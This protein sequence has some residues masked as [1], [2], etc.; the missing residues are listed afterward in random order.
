[1]FIYS[2]T[3]RNEQGKEIKGTLKASSKE[4]LADTLKKDNLVLTHLKE[5]IFVGSDSKSVVLKENKSLRISPPVLNLFYIQ[6][7]NLIESGLSI[8][9]SLEILLQQTRNAHLKSMLKQLIY[10]IEAG[11]SFSESLSMFPKTFP[12]LFINIVKAGEA[13]GRLSKSLQRFTALEVQQYELKKKIQGALIYPAIL[14]LA[15]VGV[16]LFVVTYILPQFSQIF[17]KAG[18]ELP[19]MTQLINAGGIFLKNYWV[20]LFVAFLFFLIATRIFVKTKEGRLVFDG[21]KLV[22]PVLSE[23]H[24]KMIYARFSLTMS[25]LVETGVPI[26]MSLEIVKNVLGNTVLEK[27]IKKLRFDVE[28]GEKMSDSIEKYEIFPVELV[29]MI[30]IGEESGSLDKTLSKIGAIYLV[31]LDGL[32]KKFTTLI[33]P[34]LMLIIGTFICFIMI[35]LLMPMFDLIKLIRG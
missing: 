34:A 23:I 28:R 13:S 4:A 6:L 18:I 19:Y 12:S 22:I 7:S 2:Y 15:G 9:R 21:V 16:M 27:K 14:L 24:K 25:T 10:N 30:A 26:L 20:I 29:Q 8:L 17:V 31:E 5:S 3:A 35:S 1:M 32:I 33:E 11:N